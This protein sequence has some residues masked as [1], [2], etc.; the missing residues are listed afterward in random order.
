MGSALISIIAWSVRASTWILAFVFHHWFSSRCDTEHY[1]IPGGMG[2]LQW[3]SM[4]HCL[5]TPHHWVTFLSDSGSMPS[6]LTHTITRRSNNPSVP[7]RIAMPSWVGSRWNVSDIPG[8]R[9][10]VLM[11]A[12]RILMRQLLIFFLSSRCTFC[13]SQWPESRT[14]VYALNY[15]PALQIQ[16][17]LDFLRYDKM[18]L[19]CM[20]C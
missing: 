14:F 2:T 4:I 11:G 6:S 3:V 18:E 15:N 9:L 10:W 19:Q 5:S 17:L 7:L 8:H 1:T 12:L 16:Y 20:T 13:N